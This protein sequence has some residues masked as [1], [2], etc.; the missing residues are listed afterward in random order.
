MRPERAEFASRPHATPSK[1]HSGSRRHFSLVVI[2][3]AAACGGDGPQA[4]K[5]TPDDAVTSLQV[6]APSARPGDRITISY[7]VENVG[8]DP[9]QSGGVSVRLSSDATI[10]TSDPEIASTSLSSLAP[11]VSMSVTDQPLVI[12]SATTP[13]AYYLGILLTGG[14]DAN[15]SNDSRSVAITLDTAFVALGRRMSVGEHT[16]C[17]LNPTNSVLCWGANDLEQF[18]ST[19]PLGSASPV[20]SPAPALARFADGMGQHFCGVTASHTATCWGRNQFGGIGGGPGLPFLVPP[21]LVVGGLE[22][23]GVS[24][25]RQTSC[26]VSTTG[27]GYCWG[28]NQRGEIGSASISLGS[29]NDTPHAIDGGLTFKTVVAG[30]ISACGII[31]SG[32]TYCW[33]DNTSGQLGRGFIDSSTVVTGHPTPA[34]VETTER[35]IQLT[36]GARQMCGLTADHRAFCWGDNT[37][38]QLGDGS[39]TARAVPTP[40]GTTLRFSYIATS[41]G[42]PFVAKLTLP[43]VQQGQAAFTCALTEAG[44][45]YCWGWNGGGQLGDGSTSDRLTPVAVSGN[46]HLTTL[47][48]GGTAACGLR[49]AGV[50]CW[51]WNEDGQLGNGSFAASSVPT[52]VSAPFTQP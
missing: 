48:L 40:V 39:T 17:A 3:A 20:A 43:A 33:G 19:T 21:T 35:F 18:G 4:P 52:A 46:L 25:S 12:P 26:G 7:S 41:S 9:Q 11:G 24:T 22:W 44:A 51:G 36:I 30:W 6:S 45:P 16:V 28:F 47:G 14:A 37:L 8:A 50:W 49:G 23:A 29:A 27:A 38:G 31:S 10:T 34:R 32:E 42:L 2:V 5:P 1:T 15:P 13:G